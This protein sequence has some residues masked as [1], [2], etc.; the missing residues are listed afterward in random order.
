MNKVSYQEIKNIYWKENIYIKY[1]VSCFEYRLKE[2]VLLTCFICVLPVWLQESLFYEDNSFIFWIWLIFI[3]NMQVTL[4]SYV[5][6]RRHLALETLLSTGFNNSSILLGKILAHFK[7]AFIRIF[8]VTCLL[9]IVCVLLI[10]FSYISITIEKVSLENLFCIFIS[11]LFGPLLSAI[12]GINYSIRI[13][14]WQQV[15]S[16]VR[17]VFFSFTLPLIVLYQIVN[18]INLTSTI[19]MNLCNLLLVIYIILILFY[20]NRLKENSCFEKILKCK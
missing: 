1:K 13:N 7:F 6:E 2:I 9:M 19:R 3:C 14:D 10:E 17:K 18:A 4:S 11:C 16:A 5:D 15:Q 20:F 12:I 8:I